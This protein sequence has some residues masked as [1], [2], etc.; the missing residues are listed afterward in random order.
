MK[1]Y[2][3]VNISEIYR[4]KI[5]SFSLERDILVAYHCP[6]YIRPSLPQ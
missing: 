1:A 3:N 4:K 2:Y 5:I 6:S